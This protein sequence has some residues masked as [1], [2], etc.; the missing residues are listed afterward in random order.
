[1]NENSI[2]RMI[3]KVDEVIGCLEKSGA[4]SGFPKFVVR[5]AVREVLEGLRD[6]ILKGGQEAVPAMEEILKKAER[7]IHEKTLMNL[8]PVINATGII[9]HTN[10][11]RAKMGEKAARAVT[12][13][14]AGYSTLEYDIEKGERGSRYTHV[15][16]LLTQLSGAE[17]AMVVN[18]NAAALMLILSTLSRDKKEIVISRGELIEIGDSFR[19]PEIMKASGSVLVEVGTTNKTHMFDFE[20]AIGEQTAAL[21]KVHTSNYRIVGFSEASTVEDLA[22]L[23]RKYGVPVVHDI[24]SS[25]FESLDKYGIYGEPTV[26]ESIAEGADVV[27]FSGDK[28]LGGPQA[29]VIVGKKEYIG[30]MKKNQLTRALRIDK[31]TLTALEATLR[32]YMEGTASE[33]IPTIRMIAARLPELLEK[34]AL[35]KEAILRTQADCV[36]DVWEDYSQIGGGSVPG[37]TL[38]TAVVA[39]DPKS[40]S[41]VEMESRM[42]KS[43]RPVI[44]RICRGR[45]LLDV[46]T[47]EEE[48]F[49]YIADCIAQS[50][51]AAA[52]E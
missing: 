31:L 30:A 48:D 36:I 32:I 12:E 18:N 6:G 16:K 52:A 23:G 25:S 13:A 26:R 33:D 39:V 29:G 4:A 8:R 35:F 10:L 20:N 43:D 1:M 2:L 46:R 45:L 27:C 7:M 15:E 47:L 50:S 19:I 41:V 5:E 21:L 37:Q 28:L 24:G 44:A 49:P 51:S 9:L 11:G 40:V 17:A 34:A 3:P 14:A 38:P 22:F 42:R